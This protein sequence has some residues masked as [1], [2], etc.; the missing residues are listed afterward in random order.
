M[1][2]EYMCIGVVLIVNE[3]ESERKREDDV[4]QV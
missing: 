4:K 2:T 1:V 3:K